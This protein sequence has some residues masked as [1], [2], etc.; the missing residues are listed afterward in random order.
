[1]GV[2]ELPEQVIRRVYQQ[3]TAQGE[4]LAMRQ[5]GAGG[6]AARLRKPVLGAEPLKH[7]A[8]GARP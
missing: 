6:G 3:D 7:V 5:L 8:G 4:G 1:M 2:E